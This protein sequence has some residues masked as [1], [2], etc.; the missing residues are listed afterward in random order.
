M[1]AVVAAGLYL[2][3]EEM[4][5]LEASVDLVVVVMAG[6]MVMDQQEQCQLAEEVEVAVR[7]LVQV[8]VLPVVPVS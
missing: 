5:L 7:I 6:K 1:L 4:L 3:V 8:L 2:Q